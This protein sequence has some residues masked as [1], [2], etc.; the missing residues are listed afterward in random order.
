MASVIN[1]VRSGPN[2][3]DSIVI[4]TYDEHGG[5]Y[6]HVTPPSAISPDG[7]PPGKCADRSNPPTSETPGNGAQC[8]DSAQAEQM[9][10]AEVLSGETCINSFD[11]YGIRVPFVVISPFSRPSY[12]SHTVGDHTS[13]LAL[14]E[15]RFTAN[16]HL[17]AR[18]ANA[19]DLEDLFDFTNA[20]SMNANVAP[21]VAPAPQPSDPGC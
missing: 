13:I 9:L 21:S 15:K 7:I 14:I 12:V 3:K 11:Q 19:N 4:W 8:S 17:T 1:A 6:D 20:P 2:W 10:C 5:Y 18:D 16:A